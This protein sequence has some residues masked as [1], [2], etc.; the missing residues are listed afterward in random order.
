MLFNTGEN[1]T[2]Y[3][4]ANLK[5][6]FKNLLNI[7]VVVGFC[8]RNVEW[9]M[10]GKC[11]KNVSMII[12]FVG[13]VIYRS[14]LTLYLVALYPLNSINGHFVRLLYVLGQKCLFYIY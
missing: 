8:F 7:L 3:M 11:G 14:P 6:F 1:G 13:A 4:F 12:G 2:P 5:E 10:W 9:E